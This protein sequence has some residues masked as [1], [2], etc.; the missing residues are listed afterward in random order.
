M[1]NRAPVPDPHRQAVGRLGG[2]TS[3]ANTP[4]RTARTRPARAKSPG[5]VEYFLDRLDPDRFANCSEEQ[6]LA[7]AEAARKAY[8]QRLGLKSAASR[9]RK[10][11]DAA[12]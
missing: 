5:S 10:V 2:L 1:G 7:A 6:R 9:R 11:A 3:W 4:D 8:F 12:A